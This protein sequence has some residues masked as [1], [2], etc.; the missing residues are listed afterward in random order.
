MQAHCRQEIN[1]VHCFRGLLTPWLLWGQNWRVQTEPT[2][3]ST[4]QGQKLSETS[5]SFFSDGTG[6]ASVQEI[7]ASWF[8]AYCDWPRTM[9]H[10]SHST[11]GQI[12]SA[13][14]HLL[15]SQFQSIGFWI[16]VVVLG[17]LSNSVVH[18]LSVAK[19]Y[20]SGALS[21]PCLLHLSVAFVSSRSLHF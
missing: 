2:I 13:K 4:A 18:V 17:T 10:V 15:N 21:F 19:V 1:I 9:F 6:F 20:T 3:R 12:H 5:R 8:T 7:G 16:P 14:H 11:A